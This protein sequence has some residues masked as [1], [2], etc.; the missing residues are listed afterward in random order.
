MKASKICKILFFFL[1]FCCRRDVNCY[2][3]GLVELTNSFHEVF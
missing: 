1:P 3:F 2:L